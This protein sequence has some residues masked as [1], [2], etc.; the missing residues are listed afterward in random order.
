MHYQNHE[1]NEKLSL[2]KQ[3]QW[4]NKM[5][6]L[7]LTNRDC[8]SEA[9]SS[10]TPDDFHSDHQRI[11]RA[12]YEE[13]E[14]SQG[15]RLLTR[16]NFRSKLLAQG[17]KG[18]T[19]PFLAVWDKSFLQYV[20]ADDFGRILKKVKHYSLRHHIKKALDAFVKD[21]DQRLYSQELE[22]IAKLREDLDNTLAHSQQVN[23]SPV[24]LEEEATMA[25][26]D[27][28]F[29]QSDP[30]FR[31]FDFLPPI[32][33]GEMG[34]VGARSGVGK[35]V[36]GL[37]WADSA[38]L[39]TPVLILSCEMS[40][41]DIRV[42][43]VK[44]NTCGDRETRLAQFNAYTAARKPIFVEDGHYSIEAVISCMDWYCKQKQVGF[45][46]VDYIQLLGSDTKRNSRHEELADISRMLNNAAKRN[47]CGLLVISQA[48]REG[49]KAIAKGEEAPDL[50]NIAGSDQ[51]ARDCDVYIHLA[52]G[53]AQ[54]TDAE[55]KVYT[56][57]TRNCA[58]T[59]PVVTLGF[60][61]DTMRFFS[62]GEMLGAV[63]DTD[64]KP[65]IEFNSLD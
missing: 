54:A 32:R 17:I 1:D 34:V 56:V 47:N 33:R 48:N 29:V 51:I 21:N 5:I 52:R 53:L 12:I 35:T 30:G 4:E 45:V 2:E 41:K 49:S 10:I 40:K 3:L 55:V 64:H 37:Q 39:Q 46:V 7:L 61:G 43:A 50:T 28:F 27:F 20:K 38:A 60:S 19:I 13:W 23:F 16:D 42:R 18:D 58:N 22:T 6:N 15:K 25:I 63:A 57:K 65:E 9:H 14:E 26:D 44:R 62:Q 8:I 59:C 24:S 36:M 31:L 11:V